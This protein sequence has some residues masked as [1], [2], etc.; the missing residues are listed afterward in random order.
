MERLRQ[1]WRW[2]VRLGFRLL[3]NELAW[4]YDG[5]SWLVSLGAWRA[6]QRAALPQVRGRRVLE[7]GHGPGHLLRALRRAGYE[8]VGLDLSVAMGR[9]A[10]RR[11]PDAALV[12]GRAQALPFADGRFD[13]VVATFPTDYVVDPAAIAAVHR[14]LSAA[15]R[16]VIVPEGHLT[17]RGAL[18]RLIDWLFQ[19][20]GQRSAA[21][22]ADA[23]AWA[24]F[25]RRFEAAGFAVRV[26][27]V[28][29]PGSVATVICC[30]KAAGGEANRAA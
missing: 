16:F 14:V 15:G 18:Q 26:T 17:G 8:V 22:E 10:R 1:G 27:A 28:P 23:A 7:I 25:R 6:W 4:T 24:S 12:R 30:D 21:T 2:L 19:V 9:L 13:T 3:Y 20:T 11:A 29:L 5:V